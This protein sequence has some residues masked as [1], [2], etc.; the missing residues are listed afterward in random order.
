M[1]KGNMPV[2]ETDEPRQ[3][4][5]VGLNRETAALLPSLLE[6]EGIHVIKVITLTF[7]LSSTP[8]IAPR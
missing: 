1:P 5:I 7:P 3:V 8:L 2:T 4:A 6:A